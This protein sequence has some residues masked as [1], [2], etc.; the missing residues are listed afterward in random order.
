MISGES[1]TEKQRTPSWTP[2]TV[3]YGDP[4]SQYW[5]GALCVPCIGWETTGWVTEHTDMVPGMEIFSI[6]G[7]ERDYL[8]YYRNNYLIKIIRVMKEKNRLKWEYIVVFRWSVPLFIRP[9]SAYDTTE[10]WSLGHG[11]IHHPASM[12]V[13]GGPRNTCESHIPS[14]N[15]LTQGAMWGWP[16]CPS[17]RHPGELG[18]PRSSSSRWPQSPQSLGLTMTGPDCENSPLTLIT[19]K[20]NDNP[21]FQ[22]VKL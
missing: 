9:Q 10:M 2:I 19:Q 5:L 12:I 8:Y 20:E 1:T 17:S 3:F 18:C 21:I 11:A 4:S 6:L 22:M 15:R 13:I 16:D 14:N 7:E